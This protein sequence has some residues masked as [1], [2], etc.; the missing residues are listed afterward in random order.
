[1]KR[2]PVARSRGPVR[3]EGGVQLRVMT[4]SREA[5]EPF[6]HTA[7]VTYILAFLCVLGFA[8]VKV[9]RIE[10]DSVIDTGLAGAEQYFKQHP[11]LTLPRI[12][13][14]RISRERSDKLAADFEANRRRRNSIRVPAGIRAREQREIDRML[15]GSVAQLQS[16]PEQRWGVHADERVPWSFATHIFFHSTEMHLL[17]GLFL[18][19][20][21]GYFLEGLWGSAIQFCVVSAATLGAAGLFVSQNASLSDPYIGTLGLAAGFSGAF[22]VRFGGRRRDV[23]Y[24]FVLF[25]SIL[26]LALPAWFG[27]EWSI[28]RGPYSNV[29]GVGHWNPTFWA[30]LGGFVAGGLVSFGLTLFGIGVE[31]DEVEAESSNSQMD[32]HYD[33]ALEEH[34]LGNVEEAFNILISVLR[35]DPENIDACIALWDVA[36]DLGRPGAACKSILRVIRDQVQRHDTGGAVRYW[37]EL[38]ACGLAADAESSL[39]IRMA[40]LLRSEGHEE[41]AVQAL[42]NALARADGANAVTIATRVAHEAADL[43][44]QLARDAIWKA[45]GCH[46]LGLEDRQDMESLLGVIQPL[47]DPD[48]HPEP[49]ASALGAREDSLEPTAAVS[50]AD[51]LSP[52]EAEAELGQADNPPVAIE[53]D[54]GPPVA[55]EFDDSSRGLESIVAIPTEFDAEGLM[56]EV[57]GGK[58]KRIRFDRIEAV[59]VAAIDGL[60]D[61][62]VVVIDLVLNW[63]SL[64]DEPLR[65][66][67]LRGDHFDPRRIM[68]GDTDPAQAVRAFI[69]HLVEKS[70]ATP[71]PDLQSV[72]G[73]PF[74]GFKNLISYHRDI[75][76]VECEDD[77]TC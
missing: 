69:V 65:V 57:E 66:I 38:V 43:E 56:I 6:Q 17:T 48:D 49:A 74:A 53:S 11:Y 46:E 4:P 34:A 67:R 27:L 55:L 70:D 54:D 35:R 72:S 26:L 20:F 60:G 64:T 10:A 1:M 28:P 7:W 15:E 63:M 19:V 24:Y 8:Y 33:R 71:L 42:R 36:N 12:L 61:R 30:L 62:P 23:P 21:M 75:L 68:D 52:S 73:M 45:L 25:I 22:A 14:L 32:S 9:S 31:R 37:L 40:T 76:M 2:S 51:L 47:L 16:L 13:E 59:A 44:P 77:E 39:S 18:V 5:T 29:D 41:T 58:K 50:A 3:C